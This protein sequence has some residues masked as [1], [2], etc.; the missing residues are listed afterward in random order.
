VIVDDRMRTTAPDVFAAGD[1]AEW[2]GQVA[3]LWANA[4][5]QAKVAATN[6]AG[7][8]AFYEGV[9]P[10]T[11]LKCLPLAV[12]SIGEI[13]DDSGEVTSTVIEDADAGTYKKVVFRGGIPVGAILLGATTGLGE[14]RKL[15]EGGHALRR[16]RERVLP[17][18]AVSA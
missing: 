8:M 16:L 9:L 10:V 5:E 13:A 12:V 6:A 17:P 2:Q 18:V 1:V 14:V 11:T 7:K 3:G 15:V 4:E